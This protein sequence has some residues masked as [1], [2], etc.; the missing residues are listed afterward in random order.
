M[1]HWNTNRRESRVRIVYFGIV[2]K[3]KKALHILGIEI[4]SSIIDSC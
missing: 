1:D 2:G 3:V 4:R